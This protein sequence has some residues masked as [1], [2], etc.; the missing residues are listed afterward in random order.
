MLERYGPCWGISFPSFGKT[1]FELWVVPPDYTI[2]EHS[3]PNVDI[4]LVP[5][6]GED[7][8]IWRQKEGQKAE[9]AVVTSNSNIGRKFT[10][11][12]GVNHAFK[13]HQSRFIFFN[14]ER[15]KTKPTSAA[16]DFKLK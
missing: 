11:P 14:I 5:L 16:R 4:E 7:V 8:V 15:W 2:P 12:A 13:T 9:T 6:F 3:H 1:K 10:I